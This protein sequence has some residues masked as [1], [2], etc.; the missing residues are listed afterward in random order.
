MQGLAPWKDR[1]TQHNFLKTSL[2][3]A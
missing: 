2:A 3:S 1:I